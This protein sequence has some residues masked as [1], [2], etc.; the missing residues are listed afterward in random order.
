MSS[1]PTQKKSW[2]IL[3]A[4]ASDI[5]DKHLN[6]FFKADNNRFSNLSLKTDGF[7][8]DYSKQRIT[9]DVISNLCAL[10]DESGFTSKRNAMFNG[11]II[12]NTEGRAVLHTALRRPDSDVVKVNGENIIPAVHNALNK[13]KNFSNAVRSGDHKGVTG[14]AIKKIVS[15]GIGG[16]DLGP[17]LVSEALHISAQKN[18][19]ILETKFVSNIDGD[20]IQSALDECQA[21]ETLFVII[22][23]SFKTQETLT[24]AL[25]ARQW[26]QNNLPDGSDISPHFIAVSSNIEAVENFGINPDNIFPM[27]DWVNGRFSLW[28]AVGLSLCLQHGFDKFKTLLAG[29]YNMDQHFLKAPLNE[30]LPV[31]MALIGVWNRNFLSLPQ[32]AIL[33]YAQSLLHF[34]AYLQQLEMESNGKTVDYDGQ[35]ITDYKT[36]PVLFGE[37]GTNG[38][39]SFYQLLHQGSETVPCDFIGV[40]TPE[41]DLPHHHDLLLSHMLAQGQAMMQGQHEPNE[42]YRYFEGNK[43]SS[44]LLMDKMDAYSLGQLI[45]LYEHKTFTQGV[46]WNL[47]SFDQFGVELGK[48][49]SQK[50]EKQDL[51]DAD[52][53]TKGLHS[54]IHKASK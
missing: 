20:D 8:F 47:N 12:N 34:P 28:S 11:D 53:S 38:Q 26:L 51:S 13:M 27:W 25:T 33:P 18:D 19:Q 48:E 24:N 52:P 44:T 46:I 54:L 23:K 4:L 6:D 15:I 49:L 17:R 36:C 21:E 2:N 22:S 16:S 5:Q 29:A 41:T 1:N 40:L 14:S 7:F 31:L 37:V 45:A 42:S 9:Q 10:L 39:H 50:L 43:P 3:K 30:N 35:T 32:L